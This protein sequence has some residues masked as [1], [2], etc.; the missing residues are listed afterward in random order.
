[1][2]EI[3]SVNLN[4][5]CMILK[6]LQGLILNIKT[7]LAQSKLEVVLK[8]VTFLQVDK[9]LSLIWIRPFS[10]FSCHFVLSFLDKFM[11][12]GIFQVNF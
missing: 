2:I 7:N 11:Y 4:I 6:V 1:M 12:I 8:W 9:D 3:Q 10:Y 5:I